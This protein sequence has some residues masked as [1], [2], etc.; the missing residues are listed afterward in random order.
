MAPDGNDN[1]RL[2]DMLTAARAVQSFV[3]GRDFDDY[4]RD[5]M[6]CSAVERQVEIIDAVATCSVEAMAAMTSWARAIRSPLQ[7]APGCL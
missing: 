6:L 5:L 3:T 4:A 2:W 7:Y 1:A